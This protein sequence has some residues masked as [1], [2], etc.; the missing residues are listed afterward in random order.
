MRERASIY[1]D[2]FIFLHEAFDLYHFIYIFSIYSTEGP[3]WK[4]SRSTKLT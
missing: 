3:Q 2:L 1:I 4:K